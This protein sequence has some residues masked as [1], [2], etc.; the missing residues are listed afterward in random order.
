[1]LASPQV[2]ADF[3]G[4]VTT[5]HPQSACTAPSDALETSWRQV[6]YLAH[7]SIPRRFRCLTAVS[8]VH[9]S[10]EA[11]KSLQSSGM[12]TVAPARARGEYAQIDVFVRLFRR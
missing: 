7:G 4:H 1:M 9:R 8:N 6:Q 2:R 5:F 12:E 3:R 10:G 11:V